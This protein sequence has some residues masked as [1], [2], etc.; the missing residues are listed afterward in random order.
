MA[1]GGMLEGVYVCV[2]RR[3]KGGDFEPWPIEEKLMLGQNFFL[4]L[5][6]HWLNYWWLLLRLVGQS[7]H[8]SLLLV[9]DPI[10]IALTAL[11]GMSTLSS[12]T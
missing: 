3:C 4:D 11:L 1:T 9:T 5:P 7:W 2:A 12:G 10:P 8:F 6:G